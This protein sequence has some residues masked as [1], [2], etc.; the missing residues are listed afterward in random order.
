M[1]GAVKP[2]TPALISTTLAIIYAT[3]VET[4]MNFIEFVIEP[5]VDFTLG[6]AEFTIINFGA[7]LLMWSLIF[8]SLISFINVVIS[9][10]RREPISFWR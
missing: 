3:I 10:N 9:W 7:F 6:L 8:V 1:L 2:I 4:H 5:A